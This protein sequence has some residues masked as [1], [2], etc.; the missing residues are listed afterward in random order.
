VT[1]VSRSGGARAHLPG[2]RTPGDLVRSALSAGWHGACIGLVGGCFYVAPYRENDVNQP[3]TI[4]LPVGGQQTVVLFA[5]LPAVVAAADP[6]DDPLVFLWSAP[7]YGLLDSNERQEEDVTTS[8]AV[9]PYD[10]ALDGETV[11]C[12]VI[13]QS[14]QL[15]DVLVE[16]FVELE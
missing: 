2:A 12:L 14:D 13:D 4:L 9:I 16:F 6:E 8:T 11:D 1:P 5:A 7:G 3:P 10:P 15:N